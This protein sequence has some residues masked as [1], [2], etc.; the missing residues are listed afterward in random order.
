MYESAVN[1]ITVIVNFF[2]N[3]I[4]IYFMGL[5]GAAIATAISHVIYGFTI[6]H[7]AAKKLNIII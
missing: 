2:F 5:S 7:F 4:L 3:L 1:V 6:H